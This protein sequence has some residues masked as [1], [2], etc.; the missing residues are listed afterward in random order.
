MTSYTLKRKKLALAT[1][2]GEERKERDVVWTKEA[3]EEEEK[4]ASPF[5]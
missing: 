1:N 4:D 2:M 5:F 3:E